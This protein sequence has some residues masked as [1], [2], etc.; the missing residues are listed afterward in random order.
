MRRLVLA[1][2]LFTTPAF[3]DAPMST[4]EPVPAEQTPPQYT[5]RPS[6]FWTSTQPAKGGAYKWRLLGIG[7]AFAVGGG[8]FLRRM[9]KRANAE[10]PVP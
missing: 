9:I 6:G 5:G 8:L 3:A 7:A 1:L 10:R 4:A 2:T